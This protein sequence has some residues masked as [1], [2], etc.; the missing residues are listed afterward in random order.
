MLPS[1]PT[2][3]RLCVALHSGPY[4]LM[5]FPPVASLP[6]AAQLEVPPE[7][8]NYARLLAHPSQALT[9]E[10]RATVADK[11]GS[12]VTLAECLN[13]V[14]ISLLEDRAA[15]TAEEQ[16]T[17]ATIVANVEMRVRELRD[18]FTVWTGG[19]QS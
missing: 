3:C 4:E 9:G 11:L 13:T 6:Q 8:A 2:L 7:L 15:M 16:A 10:G 12:A 19:G 1:V 14:M 18:F 17:L 5:G